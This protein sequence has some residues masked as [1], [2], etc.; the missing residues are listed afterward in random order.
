MKT[1]DLQGYKIRDY[2]KYVA[3]GLKQWKATP[4]NVPLSDLNMAVQNKTVDGVYTGW[5]LVK[6][7]K[8]YEQT[9]IIT[10]TG[11]STLWLP[12]GMN[13][14][15][16]NKLTDEQKQIFEDVKWEAMKKMEELA[17]PEFEQLKKDTEAA[18][19]VFYTL[20]PEEQQLFT[21]A[22]QPI[23][24]MVEQEVGPNGLKLI[25][26]LKTVQ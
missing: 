15:S 25:E 17:G 2:G 3:E 24:E 4:V 22:L 9:P 21:D 26:A 19:G 10:Y 13:M 16:Y 5:P 14:D 6:S 1:P 11:L 18:G 20:T 8:I 12:V 7:F 23:F